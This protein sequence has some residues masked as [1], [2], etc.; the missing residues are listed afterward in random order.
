[1]FFSDAQNTHPS[2]CGRGCAR[3]VE[4]PWFSSNLLMDFAIL[5]PKPSGAPFRHFQYVDLFLGSSIGGWHNGL[6]VSVAWYHVFMK[7]RMT[8]FQDNAEMLM[9]GLSLM[10]CKLLE[11]NTAFCSFSTPAH[12]R[13]VSHSSTFALIWL[14]PSLNCFTFLRMC[15]NASC[16]THSTRQFLSCCSYWF[17]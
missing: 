1:M 6:S 13:M 3:R 2:L 15:S 9:A 5:G 17:W 11:Q 7:H 14:C 10:T 16:G 12:S 4:H 8:D